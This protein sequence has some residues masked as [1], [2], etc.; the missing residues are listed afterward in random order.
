MTENHT[1]FSDQSTRLEVVKEETCLWGFLV[2]E[3][4]RLPPVREQRGRK[5]GLRTPSEAAGSALGTT[6]VSRTCSSVLLVTWRAIRPPVGTQ[7]FP[8]HSA[9]SW[10]WVLTC[11][12]GCTRAST[13][14]T[15]VLPIEGRK[16]YFLFLK[17]TK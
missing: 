9:F 10:P 4:V 12:Y 3:A 8:V 14:Q 6:W 15:D 7:L 16:P 13:L 1:E 11:F 2:R 5:N 17:G